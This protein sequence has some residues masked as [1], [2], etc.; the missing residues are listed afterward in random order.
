[1]GLLIDSTVLIDAERKGQ[2]PRDLFDALRERWGDVEVAIS[3][4]S[5][6]ELF[7]GCWRADSPVRR[8]RREE[9][10][11]ELVGALPVLVVTLPVARLFGEL[12]AK[13]SAAGRRVPTS[14]LLIGATA[15]SHGH[16]VVT[17]N[18]RHFR[19]V[20]GLVVHDLR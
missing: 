10:V 15:L 7:H 17:S 5:A 9:F 3:V 16:E 20:P 13:L 4:I 12:D 18:L 11:E 1:M 6:G 2:G 14:D 8:A 19:S